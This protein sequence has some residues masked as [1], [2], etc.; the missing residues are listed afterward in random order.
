LVKDSPSTASDS[1]G[2]APCRA[3]L[4]SRIRERGEREAFWWRGASISHRELDQRIAAWERRLGE[5]GI[6]PGDPLALLGDYSPES[7]CLMLALIKIGAVAVPFT[8]A[9]QSELPELARLAGARSLVRFESDDRHRFEAL[10]DA[11]LPQLVADFRQRRHPGLIVFTSGSTGRPKGIL[12]D[13]ERLIK[14]FA[15]PRKAY[16]TLLFLLMDHLGGFNTL[17]AALSYGGVLIAPEGRQPEAVART[18]ERARVELLPVTPTFLNLLLAAGS[19]AEHDLSSVQLISYG[20]EVMTEATLA[21]ITRLFP[22]AR[23]QQTYGLSELGVL[24]S[25]SPEASSTWVRIGGEGF[26][27]KVVEGLLHVRA[28]SAMVGYLNAPNPFDAEGWFNTGD[29]VEQKGEYLRILGR[30]SEMINVGGQKVFPAEVETALLEADNV[31]EATVFG[32][33]HPLMGS[34]VVARISLSQPEEPLALRARLRKH[35]LS[36]LASFKVPVKFLLT[37]EG[38]HNLRF[39]KARPTEGGAAT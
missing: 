17:L 1:P 38:Q 33:K 2:D 19:A 37:L 5:H 22:T 31:T 26:E 16:R 39:K 23:F 34:V 9:V 36:R 29:A 28:E 12:H 7:V 6:G 15:A 30:R 35:C 3:D 24:H 14:K 8:A 18:V 27:T 4:L 11:P 32:E 13:C 25:K 21:R 10:S 20:T